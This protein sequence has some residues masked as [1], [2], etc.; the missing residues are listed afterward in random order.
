MKKISR[1]L[2]AV[3]IVC[4]S[5]SFAFAGVLTKRNSAPSAVSSAPSASSNLTIDWTLRDGTVGLSYS[6]FVSASGGSWPYVWTY[7]GN[8]PPGLRATYPNGSESRKLT[9]SG[10]PTQAGT[11][12]FRLFVEDEDGNTAS[13]ALTV[14]IASNTSINY[15]FKDGIVGTYYSDFVTVSGGTAPYTWTYTGTLPKGLRATYSGNRLTLSGTPTK[16]GTYYFTFTAKDSNGSKAT[17]SFTV[18]VINPMVINY[19]FRDGS[20]GTSYSD[21]VTVSGGTAPYT[22]TYTGTLPKGLRGTYSANKMTLKGTP[23]KAGT[24]DFTLTVKDSN[25]N[26]AAKS[27]TVKV[28]APLYINYTLKN[29]RVGTPYSDYVTVSGGTAPYTWTYTGTLPKGLRGTYSGN[30]MT[31]AG[32]PTKAGTYT[33]KLTVKDSNGSKLTK[34]FTVQIVSSTD[35]I[36]ESQSDKSSKEEASDIE[37]SDGK[38]PLQKVDDT[39]PSGE[40][41]ATFTPSVIL[42]VESDDIVETYEGKDSD[43]VKVKADT[44]L[45]FIVNVSDVI[46]Y[47]DE[48]AVDDI[49]VSP[50]GKFTLPAEIVHDDFKVSAKSGELESEELFIIAE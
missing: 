33:F 42:S 7:S 12:S 49:T 36:S 22:W 23:T 4:L 44:P 46:V 21:F 9:F 24:Y 13:K 16:A 37:L 6:D 39:L 5:V 14:T 20:V 38:T 1:L 28:I 32:T 40:D 35:P 19:T 41:T 43:M 3:M 30:K 8:I 17:K 15:T 11:Y 50:E 26:K 31:L 29:G 45:H 25:G 47:V 18:K 34:S 27:F 48:K 2:L 10:T